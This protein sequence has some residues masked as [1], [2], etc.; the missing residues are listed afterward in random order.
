MGRD[1]G[2]LVVIYT[3]ELRECAPV[4]L[5]APYPECRAGGRI[6]AGSYHRAVRVVL[7]TAYGHFV[8]DLDL[9][10]AFSDRV[11]YAR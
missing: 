3:T 9:G 1:R 7:G 8:S 4:S 6:R 10:D 11:Y 5:I 2:T